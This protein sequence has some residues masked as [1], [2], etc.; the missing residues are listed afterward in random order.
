M[1]RPGGLARNRQAPLF[2][3]MHRQKQLRTSRKYGVRIFAPQKRHIDKLHRALQYLREKDSGE[4]QKVTHN[5]NAIFI[6]PLQGDYNV[7]RVKDRAW[8]SCYQFLEKSDYPY[9]YIASLLLHEAVHIEQDKQ[10]AKS[11]G[12]Q[13]EKEAYLAQR[14]FLK[15]I[16]YENAVSWLDAQFNKKWWRA[17]SKKTRLHEKLEQCFAE[18]KSQSSKKTRKVAAKQILTPDALQNSKKPSH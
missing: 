11:T 2:I 12:Y 6:A 16:K 18:F 7:L 15:K 8:L 4:F 13:A 3:F 5:L 17:L 10:G 14:R 9:Q 1:V